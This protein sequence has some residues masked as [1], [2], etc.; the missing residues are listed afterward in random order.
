MNAF[1]VLVLASSHSFALIVQL[2]PERAPRQLQVLRRKY[3]RFWAREGKLFI[4]VFAV[5]KNG[6]GLI[7]QLILVVLKRNL[8]QAPIK[9][10]LRHIHISGL[11]FLFK[12]RNLFEEI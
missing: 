2:R 9:F 6:L 8:A 11:S 10:L 3:L 5:L 4:E 1:A 12:G 7:N